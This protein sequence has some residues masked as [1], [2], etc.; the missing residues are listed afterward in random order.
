MSLRSR[1][2]S[3]VAVGTAVVACVSPGQGQEVDGKS[4]G[5]PV[6]VSPAIVRY[7]DPGLPVVEP[8]GEERRQPLSREYAPPD[9][10]RYGRPRFDAGRYDSRPNDATRNRRPY[11]WNPDRG[12]RRG[13]SRGSNRQAYAPPYANRYGDNLGSRS[14][15]RYGYAPRPYEGR[16][17]W[18]RGRWVW[19]DESGPSLRDG[20]RPPRRGYW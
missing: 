5:I 20:W 6:D 11:V 3:C 4:T 12:P 13:W 17:D 1:V 15:Q 7:Y 19:L 9:I 10:E 14:W 18:R 8:P 16:S 2:F